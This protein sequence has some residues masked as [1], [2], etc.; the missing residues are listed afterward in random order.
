MTTWVLVADNCRA[1]IFSVDKPSS[2]LTEIRD[3]TNPEARLHEGDLVTDKS[4]RDRSAGTGGSSLGNGSSHKQESIERFAMSVCEE[5]EAARV[6]D[7]VHKLY[8]I[9]APAF[10]GLLR[11]HQS[12]HIKQLIVSEMD[13]NLATQDSSAIRKQLPDYL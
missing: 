3:L 7:D 11:K 13:K 10:L 9:A 1:R 6:S 8:V 4:G 2:P 12:S 5:L